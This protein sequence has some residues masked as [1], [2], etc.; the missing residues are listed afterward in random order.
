MTA[1]HDP[2]L[3]FWVQVGDDVLHIE[4]TR[5][6]DC[7]L[8]APCS[9]NY[10][11]KIAHGLCDDLV[12]SVARAWPAD[13]P[14]ILALTM[15]PLMWTHPQTEMH[16]R[17]LGYQDNIN[18]VLETGEVKARIAMEDRCRQGDQG[19]GVESTVS[20]VQVVCANVKHSIDPRQ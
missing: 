15:H 11:A 13:K 4:L 19:P 6:A 18:F 10:L 7:L 5:W 14:I 20:A 17:M 12:T 1:Y 3:Y 8:M 16:L 9:A 2:A